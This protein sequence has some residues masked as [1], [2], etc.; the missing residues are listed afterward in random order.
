MGLRLLFSADDSQLN[1]PHA[2][3]PFGSGTQPASVLGAARCA[4]MSAS[5]GSSGEL[6][7]S[8]AAASSCAA[9]VRAARARPICGF[10]AAP[11]SCSSSP[12][13]SE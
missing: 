11:F 9:S 2:H 1:P 12:R 7:L 5:S 10:A 13:V 3:R 6:A 4:R 8:A